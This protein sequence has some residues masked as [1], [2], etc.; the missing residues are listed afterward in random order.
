[1]TQGFT[2]Q[3]TVDFAL[4]EMFSDLVYNN[5]VGYKLRNLMQDATSD[6][7]EYTKL[8][9]LFMNFVKSYSDYVTVIL[10]IDSKEWLILFEYN[11]A[12]QQYHKFLSFLSDCHARKNNIPTESQK[13]LE[14]LLN[15][16][17]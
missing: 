3:K 6:S 17:N 5:G 9:N 2:F 8:Y 11:R 4:V 10:D 13:F 15:S 14:Q 12:F 1:M 16:N 7:N